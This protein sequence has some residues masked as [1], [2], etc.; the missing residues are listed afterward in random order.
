MAILVLLALVLLPGTVPSAP[1]GGSEGTLPSLPD[2]GP[3]AVGFRTSWVLDAGRRYRTAYD[4]GTTY[5]AETAARPLLVN[6]WYPAVKDP[7]APQR[8]HGD[9]FQLDVSDER[10]APLAEALAAYARGIAVEQVL[11]AAEAA[12]D[13]A[14]RTQFAR[15]LEEPA[16]CRTGAEPLAGPFPLVVVHSGAASSYEDNA[17]LCVWLAGH[18]HVVVGSA[19]QAGDGSSLETDGGATS[20]SDIEG[21]VRHAA[22]LPFVDATRVALI[23]HSL[24]AQASLRAAATPGCPADAVVLLDTTVDYYGLSL[25]VFESLVRAV[26]AGRAEVTEPLLVFAGPQASFALVDRLEGS[27]RLYATVPDLDHDEFIA[28]GLQRL[29]ARGSVAAARGEP[30]AHPD[31]EGIRRRYAQVLELTR[32]FLDAHLRGSPERLDALSARHANGT[33]E[34]DLVVEL[35]PRGEHG[36]APYD[37]DRERPPTPRELLAMVADGGIA[38]AVAVLRRTRETRPKHP[39][40]TGT[41]LAGSLLHSCLQRGDEDGARALYEAL[42]VPGFSPVSALDFLARMAELQGEPDRART[43]LEAADRLDPGN[44]E[45]RRR[46][47]ARR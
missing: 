4:E 12:L 44:A 40:L 23:G 25:P 15:W 16:G 31:A 21:L 46:L 3:F 5:G 14:Q 10:L 13:E 41:M 11:G 26:S 38:E 28:Q 34:S 1:Q 35:V 36:P 8:R 27:E 32:A 20:V 29:A 18:G 45:R 17:A 43:L 33:L 6:L 7:D 24:G 37:L 30:L 42:E 19:F 22:T 39:I 9:Y 47:E 2:Q